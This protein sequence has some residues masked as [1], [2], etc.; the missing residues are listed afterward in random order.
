MG[1]PFWLKF[2]SRASVY[3]S[4]VPIHL[5]PSLHFQM[6]SQMANVRDIPISE[7]HDFIDL[8]KEF[9]WEEVKRSINANPALVNVRPAMRWSAL[10]Q[11]AFSG[12][13]EAVR[14][15]LSHHA[16][17]DATNSEGK[18]PIDVAK[19]DK[20]RSILKEFLRSGRVPTPLRT[21]RV[22]SKSGKSATTT[23]VM[24]VK[25]SMKSTIAKGKRAKALVYKG[26]FRKTS[27]GLTKDQLTKNK[28]GKIVSKRLQAHGKKSYANIKLWVE[29]FVEARAHMGSTGFVSLKK[30]SALYV[31]TMQLYQP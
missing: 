10:H 9:N 3:F 1:E 16:A 24:K 28:D 17:T 25:K 26:Q 27:G 4:S 13:A 22:A 7:Q 23:K 8:A 21:K 6:A 5:G 29:A 19:N 30:G 15:L 11:A 20:V 2:G 14:F 12:S 18:T 31:K